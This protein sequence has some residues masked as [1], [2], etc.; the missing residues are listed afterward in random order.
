MKTLNWRPGSE[1][2]SCDGPM[3]AL[4]AVCDTGPDEEPYLLGTYYWREGSWHREFPEQRPP[5]LG[6]LFWWVPETEIVP[7]LATMEGI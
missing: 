6:S 2:P 7:E 3:T 4:I 1:M 5:N